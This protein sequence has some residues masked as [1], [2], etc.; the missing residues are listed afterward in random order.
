MH[1]RSD[2]DADQPLSRPFRIAHAISMLLIAVST[3]M[4]LAVIIQD[5]LFAHDPLTQPSGRSNSPALTQPW[6]HP[7]DHPDPE[8]LPRIRW[9]ESRP[10]NGF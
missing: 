4:L 1:L 7:V 9:R 2:R 8:A 5:R 6:T 3:A 10:D